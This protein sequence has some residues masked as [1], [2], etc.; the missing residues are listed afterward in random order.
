MGWGSS[1]RT[2]KTVT[3]LFKFKE[4]RPFLLGDNSIGVFPLFLPLAITAFGGPE[5]YFSLAIIAFGA[6]QFVVPKYY[7]RLGKMKN[8]DSRLLI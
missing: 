1:T 6:F 5:V 3:S 4:V 2:L 8:K 7:Y